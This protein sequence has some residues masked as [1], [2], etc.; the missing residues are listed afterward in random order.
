[1][2]V[3]QKSILAVDDDPAML[4][5]L[6]K[7][8]SNEGAQVTTAGDALEALK[9]LR[10]KQHRFDL[11]LTDLRM[12]DGGGWRLLSAMQA[13]QPQIPVI[14][15]TAF[16]HSRVQTDCRAL[17]AAAFLEKPLDTQQLLAAISTAVERHSLRSR[18]AAASVAQAGPAAHQILT[19]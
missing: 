5:A 17:G 18:A 3:R 13:E 14:V 9:Y 10:S 8:L 1:M 2:F 4:R 7:V 16:G 6:E 19:A 11:V 12:P 15:I